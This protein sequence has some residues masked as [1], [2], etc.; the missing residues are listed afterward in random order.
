[1]FVN[2]ANKQLAG[3]NILCDY[4]DGTCYFHSRCEDLTITDTP[5]QMRMYDLSQS[6]LISIPFSDLLYGGSNFG[7]TDNQ[8]YLGIFR[9]TAPVADNVWTIGSILAKRYY[10]VYDASTI[11]DQRE[12]V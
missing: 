4:D 12:Y 3:S 5:L 2:H 10:V 6:Q 1:M 11:D 9:S 7:T 8:C